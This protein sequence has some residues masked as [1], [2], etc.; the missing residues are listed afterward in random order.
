MF[1]NIGKKIMNLATITSVLGIIASVIAGLAVI[2]DSFLSAIL[3]MAVG[4][5]VSWI[6][7]FVL[8]GLGRLIDNTS[9][10]CYVLGHPTEPDFEPESFGSTLGKPAAPVQTYSAPQQTYNAPVQTYMP[11]QPAAKSVASTGAVPNGY[12]KCKCGSVHAPYVTSCA[13][14]AN[15]SDMR[16]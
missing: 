15:K 14:G 12:W 5:L 9:M 13:C 6:S 3:I 4:S 16:K 1:S 11:Q 8:F 7:G 10:I 2:G